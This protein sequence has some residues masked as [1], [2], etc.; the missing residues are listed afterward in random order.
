VL[1]PLKGVT[2]LLG[3]VLELLIG[4]L[5]GHLDVLEGIHNLVDVVLDLLTG[6]DLSGL[7]IILSLELLSILN[8]T[9]DLGLSQATL[10]VGDGDL[11]L[12]V[13]GFVT[14]VDV[15]DAI[16][17]QL[18]GDLNLRDTTR[19]RGNAIKIEGTEEVVV[20]GFVT[21]TLVDIDLNA[22]L[23]IRLGGKDL[24]LLAR[25]GGVTG[26]NLG[27]DTTDSLQTEGQRSDIEEEQVLAS[28]T[29][30][31][32]KDGSLD[33]STVSDGLI[34]VDGTARLLWGKESE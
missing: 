25:D 32:V 5:S 12:L 17:I 14:S 31:T 18:V 10:I 24:H 11:V 7:G 29:T 8:H 20:L 26:D 21:L 27:H 4:D 33:G 13:G 22:S 1:Q 19:S 23:V 28:V 2:A 34:R 15:Q 9:V 3:D 16:G 6:G 30:I